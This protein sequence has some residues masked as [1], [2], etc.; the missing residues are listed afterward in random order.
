MK[1]LWELKFQIMAAILL[2]AGIMSRGEGAAAMSELFRSIGPVVLG[3]AG[4]VFLFK[5]I[6]RKASGFLEKAME[7]AQKQQ[8][9]GFTG[10]KAAR[11]KS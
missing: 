8:Q 7:E 6:K 3:G 1:I 10:A 11:S 5:G 9:G 2:A 4:I